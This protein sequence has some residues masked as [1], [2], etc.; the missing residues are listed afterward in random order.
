M[1]TKTLLFAGAAALALM[2]LA[3]GNLQA[4]QATVT[5]TVSI[6][7]TAAFQNSTTDKN[8]V[9]TTPAP[10][11]RSANTSLILKWL[12]SDENEEGNYTTGSTFPAG[13]KLVAISSSTNNSPDFQVLDKHNNF[14]VDVSDLLSV[15]NSGVFGSDISSGKTSD[16][17]G[18]AD[19]S[20]LDQ[21]VYTV[22]YDDSFSTGLVQF[23][24]TGVIKNTTTDS[25]PNSTTGVYKETQ[26]H[27][28]SSGQGDGAYEG[29]PAVVTGG[30][31]KASGSGPGIILLP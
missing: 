31:F 1:K 12:A 3:A 7:F 26:S 9:S 19:P 5:N 25:K 14:L 29:V 22:I 30:S 16:S 23:S 10:I 18:L 28:I 15:T 21:Q 27:N 11:I 13:A 2:T 4:Q 6:S 17:T 8:D 24:F 20:Q